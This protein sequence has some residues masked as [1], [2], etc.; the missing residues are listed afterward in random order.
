M[1][2]DIPSIVPSAFQS[3][4]SVLQGDGREYRAESH[5]SKSPPRGSRRALRA[6]T[7]PLFRTFEFSTGIAGLCD[8]KCSSGSSAVI[9]L[10]STAVQQAGTRERMRSVESTAMHADAGTPM[11]NR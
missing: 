6:E 3:A 10:Y 1:Y 5:R 9:P 11:L 4:V 2:P 7:H 8:N